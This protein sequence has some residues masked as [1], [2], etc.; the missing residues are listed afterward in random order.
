M[1]K[2]HDIFKTE[3]AEPLE[4]REQF[5]VS[6]RKAKTREIV[7]QKRLKLKQRVNNEEEM[8]QGS[9]LFEKDL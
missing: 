1:K 3:Q 5:A 4:K 6:L 7:Q 9:K 8:Y 2:R